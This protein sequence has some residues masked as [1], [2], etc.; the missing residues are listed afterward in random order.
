MDAILVMPV[1]DEPKLSQQVARI[2]GSAVWPTA[3]EN[4]VSFTKYLQAGEAMEQVGVKSEER[5][6]ACRRTWF[7]SILRP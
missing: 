2:M 7:R 4:M 5:Q 6:G 1:K 3:E